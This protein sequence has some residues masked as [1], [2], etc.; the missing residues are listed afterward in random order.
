[1]FRRDPLLRALDE[2]SGVLGVD[3]RP[4]RPALRVLARRGGV[5]GVTRGTRRIVVGLGGVPEDGIFELASVTK[6]FTAALADALVR[7]G[8]LEWDTP[9]STLGG[10]LRSLPRFLTARTLA[11]HTAGLPLHPAR[12]AVTTFTHFYDPYGPLGARDVVASARRWATPGGRF[13]YS[14]LGAGV[15]ALALAHAAG[16]SADA[17]GYARALRVWVT[18]PLELDVS[19]APGAAGPLVAPVGVLG[20]REFTAFGPLVGAGGLYGHAGDLLAFAQ[21]HLDGRAGTHWQHAARPP[22]LPPLLS[23][24]APGWFV[25]GAGVRWHDGVARGTR[26]GLGF[27]PVSGTA[28]TLLVRGG[29]PLVGGRGTLPHV[30]LALLGAGA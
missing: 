26:T 2:V 4:L 7:A 11:T 15:L 18:G 6:P 30:L 9:V 16:E 19:T 14:N 3:A 8:R 1:M 28:A 29:S 13:G 25:S 27:D 17:T 20:S 24:L 23:G 12:V 21:A 22:G 5:L 10:P